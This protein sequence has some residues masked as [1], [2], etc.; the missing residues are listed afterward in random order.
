MYF[1]VTGSLQVNIILSVNMH[2]TI[3]KALRH[4]KCR[5]YDRIIIMNIAKNRST[6][7]TL[8]RHMRRLIET[9]PKFRL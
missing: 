2:T 9:F 1:I 5:R 6:T 8:I 4:I 3:H 7:Q